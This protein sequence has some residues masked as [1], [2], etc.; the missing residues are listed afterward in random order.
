VEE[1]DL[2]PVAEFGRSGRPD[3]L[4]HGGP[5]ALPCTAQGTLRFNGRGLCSCTCGAAVPV[6][7]TRGAVEPDGVDIVSDVP[8]E[9]PVAGDRPAVS[10]TPAAPMAPR[11]IPQF[12]RSPPGS[13]CG[14]GWG[15]GCGCGWG[16]G[17]G[18][19]CGCGCGTGCLAGVDDSPPLAV[20][21]ALNAASTGTAC[22]ESAELAPP[23]QPSITIVATN[24]AKEIQ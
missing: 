2:R 24:S 22:S 21:T 19:G 17:W 4:M 9:P 10:L 8:G 11:R 14:V 18:C 20:S 16:W 3:M 23:R 6:S 1:A 7:R 12:G 13:G 15:W 5:P